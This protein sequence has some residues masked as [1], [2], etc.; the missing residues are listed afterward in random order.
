[1]FIDIWVREPYVYRYLGYYGLESHMS[2]MFIDIR[3][4]EPYVYRHLC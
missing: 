1:M 4:S 2:H 3:V